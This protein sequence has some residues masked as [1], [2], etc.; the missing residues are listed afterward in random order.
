VKFPIRDATARGWSRSGSV[1]VDI[2]D[3]KKAELAAR[4]ERGAFSAASWSNAPFD[5]SVREGSDRAPISWSIAASKPAWQLTTA[6]ILGRPDCPI[7]RAAAASG[8]WKRSSAR[9]W[10]TPANIVAREVHFADLGPEWTYE[11]K[12]PIRGRRR[13]GIVA[14]GGVAIDISD[15]KKAQM[16]LAESEARLR[17][18]PSSRRGSPTG[19]GSSPPSGSEEEYRWS[20]GLR[21]CSWVWRCRHAPERWRKHEHHHSGDRRTACGASTTKCAPGSTTTPSSIAPAATTAVSLWVREIAEVVRDA[22]GRR[23][24]VEGTMQDITDQARRSKNSCGRPRRWRSIGPAHGRAS[25]TTST[26]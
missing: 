11:V 7:C 20:P 19:A 18:G 24:G 6:E 3:R 17:V 10:K 21:V 14:L 16:A 26:T 9:S 23:V 2:G 12:F 22:E 5:S 4:G 25:P 15:R 1:A 8:R 13:R